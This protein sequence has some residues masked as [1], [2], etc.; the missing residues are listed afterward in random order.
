M[1]PR[2]TVGGRTIKVS[3]DRDLF[4][5][6]GTIVAAFS[7][8][9]GSFAT[10]PMHPG[11]S[12]PAFVVGVLSFSWLAASRAALSFDWRITSLTKASIRLKPINQVLSKP[13]RYPMKVAKGVEKHVH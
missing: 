5:T 3:L 8:A 4:L 13:T 12:A 2:F 1:R 9:G 10:P 6:P 7:S 11:N